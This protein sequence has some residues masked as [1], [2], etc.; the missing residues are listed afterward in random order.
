MKTS[1]KPY[2]NPYFAGVLLGIVLFL[3]LAVHRLEAQRLGG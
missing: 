1:A 3:G 2:L